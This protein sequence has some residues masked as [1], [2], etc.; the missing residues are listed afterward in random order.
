[1]SI[2][3]RLIMVNLNRDYERFDD[4]I[5]NT[6]TNMLS[7]KG[8]LLGPLGTMTKGDD[9]QQGGYKHALYTTRGICEVIWFV[10]KRSTL[11]FIKEN[12][13]WVKKMFLK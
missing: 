7:S 5:I 12:L 8:R 13:A 1:M 11:S 4:E 2:C 3:L 6:F 9:Q 10:T